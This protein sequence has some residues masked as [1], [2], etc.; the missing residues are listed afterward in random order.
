[1]LGLARDQGQHSR[2]VRFVQV[3]RQALLGVRVRAFRAGR[4]SHI[5]VSLTLSAAV[6]GPVALPADRRAPAGLPSGTGAG[7]PRALVV[8]GARL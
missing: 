4:R 6:R 8:P 7:L 1:M 3:D 2:L 5:Q